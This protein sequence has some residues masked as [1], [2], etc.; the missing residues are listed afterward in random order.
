MLSH[1]ALVFH[2]E[3]QGDQADARKA[4]HMDARGVRR[5]ATHRRPLRP[6]GQPVRSAHVRAGRAHSISSRGAASAALRHR[7]PVHRGQAQGQGAHHDLAQTRRVHRQLG[8]LG[9]ASRVGASRPR[10][11]QVGHCRDHAQRL[12]RHIHQSIPGH[13][14]KPP[15]PGQVDREALRSLHR[16]LLARLQVHLLS[17]EYASRGVLVDRHRRPHQDQLDPAE[18]Q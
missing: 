17:V 4:R 8:S 18:R 15:G 11:A 5:A 2:I 10:Q 16:P 12:H 1:P 13:A 14:H 6:L 7:V 9:R 3:D